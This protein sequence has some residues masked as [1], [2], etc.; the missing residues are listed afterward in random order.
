WPRL[1]PVPPL[2]P[3]ALTVA[4]G[5]HLLG[6]LAPS[7]AYAIETAQGLVLVDSGLEPDA[8]P[9][10][11]ELAK[12]GLDWRTIRAVLLTHAHGDHTG[13]AA[14]LRAET[15]A[16]VYAGE[17]D[18]GVLRDGSSREAFFSTFSMPDHAPRPTPVD[19]EL[20]GDE[21]LD[22]GD[23]RIRALATPGHTPGSI[24]Y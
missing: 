15:G 11:A 21:V 16:K 9:V 13:G 12:L 8:G 2:R 17:G 10:K 5:V 20:G 1:G 14:A 4:P 24:C 23:V 3:T 18:A 6:D 22:F 7:A 19:V